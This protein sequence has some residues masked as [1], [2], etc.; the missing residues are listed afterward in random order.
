MTRNKILYYSSIALLIKT[1]LGLLLGVLSLLSG[2]LIALGLGQAFGADSALMGVVGA[3]LMIVMLF[4][5]LVDALHLYAAI[6]GYK[7]AD[8]TQVAHRLFILGVIMCVLAVI[9]L[10][11]DFGFFELLHLAI[12]GLYTVGAYELKTGKMVLSQHL[13]GT[14]QGQHDSTRSP[15]GHQGNR[16]YPGN[17]SH[18]GNQ[19]YTG[20]PSYPENQ[21]HQEN[22]PSDASLPEDQMDSSPDE[23]SL[24]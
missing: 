5:L 10:L 19:P 7:Y 23:N 8:N 24:S 3:S 21:T 12:V 4:A 2:G 15:Y 11:R 18:P 6:M 20:N 22:L 14:Q 9:A 16:P 13:N 1:A 17:Q